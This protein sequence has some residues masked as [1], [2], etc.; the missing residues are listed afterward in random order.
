MPLPEE[1]PFPLNSSVRWHK[2]NIVFLDIRSEMRLVCVCEGSGEAGGRIE[3][4]RKGET[5][6]FCLPPAESEEQSIFE[7]GHGA[8]DGVR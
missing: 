2:L 8:F 1:Y 6:I 5:L 4:F 3:E 7:E